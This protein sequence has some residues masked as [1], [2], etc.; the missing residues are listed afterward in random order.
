MEMMAIIFWDMFDPAQGNKANV[1][2]GKVCRAEGKVC[3]RPQ[4]PIRRNL[5][6]SMVIKNDFSENWPIYD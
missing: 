2:A 3:L 6:V 1:E 5:T 4:R